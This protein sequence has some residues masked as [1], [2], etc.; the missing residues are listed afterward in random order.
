MKHFLKKQ[1]LT[2][3]GSGG[4]SSPPPPPPPIV[5]QYPSVLVPPS[6]GE[7]DTITSFSYAEMIDLLS[8]GPIEGIVNK[9]GRKVYDDN[10]F[11]GIYLN[12]VP[13]K[14]TSRIN[15]Q[16]IPISKLKDKLKNIWNSNAILNKES[17]SIT[18]SCAELGT[19]TFTDAESPEKTTSITYINDVDVSIYTPKSSLVNFITTLNASFDYLELIQRSF[20]LSP[21][22]IE[23]PFLT[24]VTLP[25]ITIKVSKFTFEKNEGTSNGDSPLQLSVSNLA[26]Y[27]YFSIGSDLLT[28]FN[29]FELPRTFVYN[30]Y[31]NA[32]GKKTFTKSLVK[33]DEDFLYYD[34]FNLKLFIWSIYNEEVGIKNIDFVLDKYFDHILLVQ[35][36]YSLYNFNMIESELKLGNE[37]QTPL[38][39][40]NEITIDTNYD[41]ELVGPF[42]LTNQISNDSITD[43]YLQGGVQRIKNYQR[44]INTCPIVNLNIEKETSD[45]IRYIQNWPIEYDKNGNPFIISN[46][47]TNYSLFDRSS[48]SRVEQDAIPVTHYI[49]N[50]NVCNVFVTISVNSL[51]DTN[52]IDMVGFDNKAV[53]GSTKSNFAPTTPFGTKTYS[54]LPGNLNILA[55][56]VCYL[57]FLVVKDYVFDA[58]S[59]PGLLHNNIYNILYNKECYDIVTAEFA[60]NILNVTS[61]INFTTKSYKPTQLNRLIEYMLP[62]DSCIV[63]PNF[64]LSSYKDNASTALDKLLKTKDDNQNYKYCFGLSDK[65][66]VDASS[67]EDVTSSDLVTKALQPN[68]SYIESFAKEFENNDS[69]AFSIYSAKISTVNSTLLSRRAII[70]YKVNSLISLSAIFGS[71]F[72]NANNQSYVI[73]DGSEIA[74]DFYIQYPNIYKYVVEQILSKKNQFEGNRYKIDFGELILVGINGDYLRNTPEKFINNNIGGFLKLTV[75]DNL[76]EEHLYMPD[77]SLGN[78]NSYSSAGSFFSSPSSSKTLE[79]LL[80][81]SQLQ[82]SNLISNSSVYRFYFNNINKIPIYNK[83]QKDKFSESQRLLKFNIFTGREINIDRYN[84]DLVDGVSTANINNIFLPDLDFNVIRNNDIVLFYDLITNTLANTSSVLSNSRV[85][86]HLRDNTTGTPEGTDCN[87]SSSNT[88]C[89]KKIANACQSI[90][91]GTK[92]PAIVSLQI[93]TGYDSTEQKISIRGNEYFSYKFDIFGIAMTRAMLDLGKRNYDGYVFGREE[94]RTI[95]SAD[96]AQQF[97]KQPM[98]ISFDVGFWAIHDHVRKTTNIIFERGIDTPNQLKCLMYGNNISRINF[99]ALMVDHNDPKDWS[100]V[101]QQGMWY[102]DDKELPSEAYASRRFILCSSVGS[103]VVENYICQGSYRWDMRTCYL[104]D[105]H[106][107]DR[108]HPRYVTTPFVTRFYRCQNKRA[109]HI[110]NGWNLHFR[111]DSSFNMVFSDTRWTRNYDEKK[112]QLLMLRPYDGPYQE[113]SYPVC[114]LSF[115]F[116]S[117]KA[118]VLRKVCEYFTTTNKVFPTGV[119]ITDVYTDPIIRETQKQPIRWSDGD[120][121]QNVGLM[122]VHSSTHD[123]ID[124]ACYDTYIKPTDNNHHSVNRFTFEFYCAFA[125]NYTTLKQTNPYKNLY[126]NDIGLTIELPPPKADEFGKPLK[127]YVKVTRLS[128]ETLSSMISKSIS[129]NKISEV[130]KEQFSYP[131]SSIVGTKIDARSFS[132]I[133]V[134]TFTCKLKK[135]LVPSNYFP[136]NS[137]GLDVRY[138]GTY[139]SNPNNQ[140][141][142]IYVGDWDGLF[143]YAWTDNPAWILLDLLIN[144]RYGLG[145]YI[146]SEQVDIWELYKIARWCDGVDDRGFFH[147][148]PDGLRGREPRHSFNAHLGDKFNVFD[149]INQVASVFR[150]SVYYMN[151]LI[152]FCDDRPKPVIGEFNNN[153]VKDGLFNY[154]NHKKDDEFTAVE[155]AYIDSKDSYKPKVE[156]IEDSEAIRKRGVL[157]KQFNVF[158]ITS[159][160]QARRFGLNFLY[161]VSKENTNLSFITDTKALLY[162]PGDLINI[163]DELYNTYRNFGVIRKI[164]DYTTSSFKIIIDN[165][166]DN[167]IY[168]DKEISL[169]VPTSKPKYEDIYSKS[170]FIP[171]KINISF[172]AS[173][174]TKTA[175]FKQ[176]GLNTNN[177]NQYALADITLP[178]VIAFTPFGNLD[179]E[180]SVSD[181]SAN[182]KMSITLSGAAQKNPEFNVVL[183]LKY[184]PYFDV[185][186]AVSKYGHW[187]LNFISDKFDI[188]NYIKFDCLTDPALKYQLPHKNYFFEYIDTVKIFIENGISF[189]EVSYASYSATIKNNSINNKKVFD[190][191]SY[192][193]PKISYTDII[194]N[195]K[196]SIESFTIEDYNNEQYIDEEDKVL[197][198]YSVLILSKYAIDEATDRK[199][200]KKSVAY[201]IDNLVEGSAYSLKIKN[202]KVRTFKI[203]SIIENYINEYQIH[204]TEYNLNKFNEMDEQ[205]KTE[206][207]LTTFHSVYGYTTTTNINTADY[208]QSPILS[209]FIRIKYNNEDY[210]EARWSP[211]IGATAYELYLETP[212]KQTPNFLAT[213]KSSALIDNEFIFRKKLIDL[214][215][216]NTIEIGT[217]ILKIRSLT[218]TKDLGKIGYKF[219]PE[220]QRSLIILDY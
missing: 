121:Y 35:N 63:T 77:G 142:L 204:A 129:L 175:A 159:K 191:I 136:I 29:S 38:R 164:E 201:N 105:T 183:N 169:Y 15:S 220:A 14:E 147:G 139:I 176:L 98:W 27:I 148:S 149:M 37:I 150:G 163:N 4:G 23:K 203:S 39:N 101:A 107:D 108:H 28:S 197:N 166:I 31:I 195:D 100:W 65:E 60:N 125:S 161:Q 94:H 117:T 62:N 128:H 185:N 158:G 178:D 50:N 165:H 180:T 56:Q 17:V 138:L 207:L 131:F 155:V 157:K 153:D 113:W 78:F 187:Q 189:D 118:Q 36:N 119:V 64:K 214:F 99:S 212:S 13:V 210:L 66:C 186:N 92:L 72:K 188:K 46:L 146:E 182:A 216:K 209:S 122:C 44:T 102:V 30:S 73:K 48:A 68:R 25:K 109:Y 20:D 9:D 34:I 177:L 126:A 115:D 22:K 181:F 145:N 88:A 55:N 42:K 12:E 91:A 87:Y 167:S 18:I 7:M 58:N 206:D 172:L 162:K 70:A 160:S 95:V 194:E 144:K 213:V 192:S 26:D 79:N 24:I 40:F 69:G 190:I 93:E 19:E 59:N 184:I 127:R 196:P 211:I 16:K 130:I 53:F 96:R 112:G 97:D 198:K 2:I 123:G 154:T 1:N 75:L 11:E 219:S 54:Q 116:L 106:G 124:Q 141:D 33:E 143:K 32:S 74:N 76:L 82:N 218:G 83:E 103:N 86:Y 21:I 217:Y 193:T 3:K 152:T 61:Y 90:S 202:K 67:L 89:A 114:M 49:E 134:R 173:F 43:P 132:Q 171:E 81:S 6:V 170:Q 135:V 104:N 85:E 47:C 156:Y 120:A 168:E 215:S 179:E 51:W 45:D 41:K 71:N 10:I 140:N 208:I 52:H 8:D 57:Y 110:Q 111:S 200:R 205:G 174:F 151:S 5:S 133:P 137:D 199:T 80:S 84:F